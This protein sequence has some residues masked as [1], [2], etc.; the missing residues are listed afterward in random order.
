MLRASLLSALSAVVT[1]LAT[2]SAHA[3]TLRVPAQYPTIQA[4]VDAASPGDHIRVSRG[5]Y[6]GA[7]LTK[8]VSLEGR[9][10]PHIIGCATSPVITPEL[11]AGFYLPGSL[12]TNPAS[13][14]K[15]RGFVFDG[16]GVSNK[17]L[18]PL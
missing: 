14:S 16:S 1:L 15:I 6:C 3:A 4:A 2:V 9:G 5:R 8:P 13:G 11:R 18:A 10:K 17:N 12:G 7:T